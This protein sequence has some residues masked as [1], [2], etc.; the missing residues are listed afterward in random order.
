MSGES[1]AIEAQL[2]LDKWAARGLVRSALEKV[3]KDVFNITAPITP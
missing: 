3:R 1:A 2:L